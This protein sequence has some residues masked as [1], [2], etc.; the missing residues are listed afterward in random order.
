MYFAFLSRSK[1]WLIRGNGYASGFL[2]D[3]NQGGTVRATRRVD[4]SLLQQRVHLF[5]YDPLHGRVLW[6]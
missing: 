4:T 5:V 1:M 2:P 3:E 6:E